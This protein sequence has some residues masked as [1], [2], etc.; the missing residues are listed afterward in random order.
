[1]WLVAFVDGV[2]HPSFRTFCTVLIAWKAHCVFL[3]TSQCERTLFGV[4]AVRSDESQHFA[5]C[6]H[7]VIQLLFNTNA[8]WMFFFYCKCEASPVLQQRRRR[9]RR[10]VHFNCSRRNWGPVSNLA[11]RGECECEICTSESEGETKIMTLSF[12]SETSNSMSEKV[13]CECCI[14]V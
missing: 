13:H 6:E 7:I 14:S 2:T 9:R 8:L 5:R 1:M 10:L 3:H 12:G 4:N 11:F